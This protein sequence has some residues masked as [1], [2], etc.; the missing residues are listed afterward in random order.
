LLPVLGIGAFPIGLLIANVGFYSWYCAIHSYRAY[1]LRFPRF[2]METAAP[3][4]VLMVSWSL[5]L[6][7][8]TRSVP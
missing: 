2:E 4:F 5:Y 7:I 8:C 6:V 1:A 3:A